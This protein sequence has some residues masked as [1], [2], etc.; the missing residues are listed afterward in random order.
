M[1]EMAVSANAGCKKDK[2]ASAIRS[3]GDGAEN[4]I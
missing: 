2:Y 1:Q 3:W 4:W